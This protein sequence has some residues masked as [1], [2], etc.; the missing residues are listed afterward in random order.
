V[1]KWRVGIFDVGKNAA[2]TLYPSA[3]QRHLQPVAN[4]LDAMPVSVADT[5]RRPR[6][7]RKRRR[8]RSARS[9][10][11][12]LVLFCCEIDDNEDKPKT[13]T[14]MRRYTRLSNGFS[15]KIENHMAAVA[16]QLLR[17][18]F[19]QDPPL[20]ARHPGDGRRGDGAAVGRVGS[21]GA[22]GSVGGPKSRVGG[23]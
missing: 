16:S 17:E 14:A 1:I 6:R 4:P 8:G 19:H 21:R 23:M 13:T 18:Q 12:P 3:T 5:V 2:D 11:S 9:P 22:A 7:L 10:L 15:R 20:A